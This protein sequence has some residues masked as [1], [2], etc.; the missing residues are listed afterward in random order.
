MLYAQHDLP[1]IRHAILKRLGAERGVIIYDIVVREK[2]DHVRVGVLAGLDGFDALIVKS[3]F[4]VPK[5]FTI[6]LI[7]NEIDQIAEQYKAARLD[8]WQKGR[9]ELGRMQEV[10]LAG[11]GLR[12]L[13]PT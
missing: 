7:H 9:P 13:W 4:E 10:P 11:T 12:G 8:Y 1:T 6:E 3:C 2:K 5:Q